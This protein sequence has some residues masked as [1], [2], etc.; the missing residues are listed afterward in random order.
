MLRLRENGSDQ[1]SDSRASWQKARADYVSSRPGHHLDVSAKELQHEQ[2]VDDS[3]K[4]GE[5]RQKQ[6]ITDSPL[7]IDFYTRGQRTG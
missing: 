4:V 1:T 7:K 6:E 5:R 3:L 2:Q